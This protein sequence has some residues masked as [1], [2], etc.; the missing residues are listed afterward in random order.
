MQT[1]TLTKRASKKLA[2]FAD[3]IFRMGRGVGT[4]LATPGTTLEYV[5]WGVEKD[6]DVIRFVAPEGPHVGQ[7]AT[8]CYYTDRAPATVIAVSPNGAKVTVRE[9]KA[10]RTDSNG[11]SESQSYTFEPDS[12][13]AVH[14]FH[15]NQFGQYKIAG[16]GVSLSLGK[17]SAYHDYSF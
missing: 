6:C 9:D 2:Q 8:I 7:A 13:G 14:V 15:R 11:M 1:I 10:I 17:R 5:G 16:G 3:E 4:Y 12:N